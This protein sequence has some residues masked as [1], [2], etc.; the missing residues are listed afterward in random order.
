M[1]WVIETRWKDCLV[2]IFPPRA[3]YH[4]VVL[5]YPC[6]INNLALRIYSFML[7][8]EKV[9]LQNALRY[10]STIFPSIYSM[11]FLRQ[12]VPL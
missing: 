1:Y 5:A 12:S 11:V 3:T 7:M 6:L 4:A 10:F 8:Q 2:D 9:Y